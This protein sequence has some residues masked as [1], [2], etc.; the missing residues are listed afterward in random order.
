MLYLFQT[1]SSNDDA[2]GDCD[3]GLIDF[4][5]QSIEAL[6]EKIQ[7]C[8][9]ARHGIPALASISFNDPAPPSYFTYPEDE[10]LAEW[11]EVLQGDFFDGTDFLRVEVAPASLPH[12]E[13]ESPFWRRTE[14]NKIVVDDRGMWF[15]CRP[16][17]CDKIVIES[18]RLSIMDLGNMLAAYDASPERVAKAQGATQ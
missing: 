15:R 13:I 3:Y 6:L 1:T 14:F 17:H 4:T 9:T 16:K 7:F 11:L 12:L 10:A 5:R 18:P 8:H 2:N